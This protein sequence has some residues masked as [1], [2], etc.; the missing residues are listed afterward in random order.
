MYD[1]EHE[2]RLLFDRREYRAGIKNRK[3]SINGKPVFPIIKKELIENR[4]NIC[5]LKLPIFHLKDLPNLKE[6]P[7]FKIEKIIIGYNFINEVLNIKRN[8]KE[9]CNEQLE[10]VPKIEQT[11]LRKFYWDLSG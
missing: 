4:N 5:Y 6:I 1:I 8:P 3:D 10:Y 9:I 7:L 11:R 2:V